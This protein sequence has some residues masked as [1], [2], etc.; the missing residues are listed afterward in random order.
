MC[1]ASFSQTLSKVDFM[2]DLEFLKRA[3]PVKHTNLFAKIDSN[4]FKIKV[5]QVAMRS[6]GFDRN[7]FIVELFRLTKAIGD[8]HTFI[9]IE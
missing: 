2:E 8:E 6:N 3:L 1:S 4:D 7:R 5:D 9:R